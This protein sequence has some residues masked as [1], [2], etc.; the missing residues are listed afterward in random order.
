MAM[1][2]ILV[3]GVLGILGILG[4]ALGSVGA[5]E[6]HP[7]KSASGYTSFWKALGSY[8]RASFE[9]LRL[10][11]SVMFSDVFEF[12]GFGRNNFECGRFGKKNFA[13]RAVSDE[14]FDSHVCQC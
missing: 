10:W 11:S 1:V 6:T 8:W 3:I 13:K 5:P 12:A 2:G 7:K 4:N 14:N 9:V